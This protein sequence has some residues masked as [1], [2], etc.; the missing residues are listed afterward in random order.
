M[1]P[2]NMA[3]IVSEAWDK[4]VHESPVVDTSWLFARLSGQ[5]GPTYRERLDAIPKNCFGEVIPRIVIVRN[6][7]A[8]L[9]GYRATYPQPKLPAHHETASQSQAGKP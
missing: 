5:R 8:R 3:Q 7:I 6:N 1:T 9:K 4:C 2:P